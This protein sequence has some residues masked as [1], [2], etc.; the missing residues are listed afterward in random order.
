MISF[1]QNH[2]LMSKLDEIKALYSSAKSYRDHGTHVMMTSSFFGKLSVAYTL[3]FQTVLNGKGQFH[4]SY[5]KLNQRGDMVLKGLIIKEEANGKVYSKLEY[6]K[7]DLN[8][9]QELNV[10]FKEAIA[11]HTGVSNQIAY[12]VPSLLYGKE[13]AAAQIYEGK[14]LRETEVQ[15]EGIPC[16]QLFVKRDIQLKPFDLASFKGFAKEHKLNEEYVTTLEKNKENLHQLSQGAVEIQ[17]N[18][19]YY[20]RLR[21]LLLIK[22]EKTMQ[23]G[24]HNC[25][26]ETNYHRPELF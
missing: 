3:T 14:E 16:V 19:R 21:D 25:E 23:V 11:M 7:T 15:I 24:D 10:S 5:A 1:N 17:D 22:Q 8:L 9:N 12:I 6:G 4:F 2:F 13:L 18:S 26:F 20:F